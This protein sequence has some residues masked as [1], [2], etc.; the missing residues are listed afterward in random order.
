MSQKLFIF[1]MLHDLALVEAMT[2][3]PFEKFSRSSRFCGCP[4][5]NRGT[6]KSSN[7]NRVFHYIFTIHFGSFPPFFG[8]TPLLMVFQKIWRSTNLGST[9][10]AH[11]WQVLGG[12]RPPSMVLKVPGPRPLR[13]FFTKT[14]SCGWGE[15]VMNEVPYIYIYFGN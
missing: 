14:E 15:C 6:P 12:G 7:F 3:F 9:D 4:S 8:L 13:Q 2:F 11:K 5:K 1:D 10:V